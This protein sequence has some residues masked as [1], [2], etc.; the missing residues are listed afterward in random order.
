MPRSATPTSSKATLTRSE[1]Q[2][3]GCFTAQFG[4]PRLPILR[5]QLPWACAWKMPLLSKDDLTKEC[6]LFLRNKGT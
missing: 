4:L 1:G 6:R 3:V 2:N 5:P